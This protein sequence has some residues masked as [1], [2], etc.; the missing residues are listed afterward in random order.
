MPLLHVLITTINHTLHILLPLRDSLQHILPLIIHSNALSSSTP[1]SS[2]KVLRHS[3]LLLNLVNLALNQA[4]LDSQYNI[5]LGLGG[6]HTQRRRDL[7]VGHELTAA[8][9]L[10]QGEQAAVVL[11][12]GSVQL[13]AIN[14]VRMVFKIRI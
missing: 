8:A 3:E 11:Q 12:H 1:N 14:H 6:R 10:G 13:V 7:R 9:E 2:L 5:H 4:I